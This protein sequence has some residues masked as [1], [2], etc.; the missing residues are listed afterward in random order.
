MLKSCHRQLDSWIDGMGW[1]AM[2][3]EP[4]KPLKQLGKIKLQGR[5]QKENKPETETLIAQVT[6]VMALAGIARGSGS[7]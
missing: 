4:K 3:G 5:R 2:G 1:D 7:G 6:L